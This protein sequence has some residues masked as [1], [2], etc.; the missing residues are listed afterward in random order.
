[1]FCRIYLLSDFFGANPICP[2]AIPR[3]PYG[4]MYKYN[5][6]KRIDCIQGITI[7]HR[8]AV[9][10]TYII[11]VAFVVGLLFAPGFDLIDELFLLFL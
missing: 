1:M 5:W 2:F 8:D 4:E 6:L 9:D 7:G 3:I 11:R 10:L